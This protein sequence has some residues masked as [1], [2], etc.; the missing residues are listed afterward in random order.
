MNQHTLTIEANDRPATLERLLRVIR[1]RGFQLCKLSA[2]ALPDSDLVAIE[3]TVKSE[4]SIQLL[5]NQLNKLVDVNEAFIAS[6][7]AD[8]NQLRISA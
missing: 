5:L 7:E 1:H 6:T 4:R 3:A 8:K 2:D